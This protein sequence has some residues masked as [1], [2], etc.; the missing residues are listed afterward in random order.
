MPTACPRGINQ[1]L[2]L[3]PAFFGD[4]S[5][6]AFGKRRPANVAEA[7]KENGERWIGKHVFP[8]ESAGIPQNSSHARESFLAAQLARGSVSPHTALCW[9]QEGAILRGKGAFPTSSVEER[10][11]DDQE[12]KIRLS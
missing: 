5:H 8:R 11:D 10:S 1:N 7:D 12:R 9:L 6:N 3:H 2:P 4:G